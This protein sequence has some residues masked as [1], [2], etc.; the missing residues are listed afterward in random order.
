MELVEKFEG[1]TWDKTVSVCDLERNRKYPILR[2]K[3]ISNKISPAVVLTMRDSLEDPA[4]VFLPKRYSDFVSDDDIETL[5]TN[6]V[7]LNLVYRG[8]CAATNAYL[9]A[10]AT[11][12]TCF[13][14]IT[15]TPYRHGPLGKVFD[16]STSLFE[17]QRVF[18]SSIRHAIWLS[19]L[20]PV[21]HIK[22]NRMFEP[23]SKY[24]HFVSFLCS[25]IQ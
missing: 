18:Y 6:G 5:N 4:Q 8:V 25:H 11:E 24:V 13:H 21:H 20:T 14:F 23:I 15:G 7:S 9:L 19:Q 2:A 16:G 3:R 1:L 10:I 22:H 12:C 17:T